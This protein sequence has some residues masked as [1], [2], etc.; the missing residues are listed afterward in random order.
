[1]LLALRQALE[2]QHS[3]RERLRLQDLAQQQNA[4]LKALNTLLEK[5]VA[6]RTSEL[7]QTADMLDLAYEELKHS[8]ATG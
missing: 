8:Y 4:E 2:H 3:E 1:M 5:R 6:A 7:Q